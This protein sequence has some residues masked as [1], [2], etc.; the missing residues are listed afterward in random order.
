MKILFW[1]GYQNP[2]WTKQTYLDNGI[3]GS[4][5]CVLKLADYLDL[6]GHDV[7]ISGD[8]NTGNYWGVKYI[9]RG[10]LT[11]NLGP[12]GLTQ[13]NE[14]QA[15][16]HYDV[17][18]ATNYLHY[19]KHL[20]DLNIDFDRSY[21]WMHNEFFYKWYRGGELHNWEQYLTHDKLNKIVGVSEYHEDILKN[22]FEALGY[23]NTQ[24]TTYIRSIDNA[25]DLNDYKNRKVLPKIKGRIVWTSSPDR[26]LDMILDNWSDWKIKQPDLTLAICS[27]PYGEKWFK[28]DIKKLDGVEW[29]GAQNPDNLKNEID[30]AEYWVYSSDYVETYC[31][32]ALEMMM[33]K[34]KILTNG[35]GNIMNLIGKGS[36]GEICDMNPD[37]IIDTLIKDTTDKTFSEAWMSKTKKAYTWASKQNWNT[38]TDEWLKMITK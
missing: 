18:I 9:N 14:V 38:R 26:G 32:S 3:G 36:R 11:K 37:T 1:V 7:T 12:R 23:N 10:D 31:I 27:P 35:T 28:R 30:K 17:V 25:I 13:P 29:L 34:V 15:Y 24:L 22:E 5:Y 16:P 4:E 2:Y 33:G 20:E 21:F 19:I 8:V 6:K